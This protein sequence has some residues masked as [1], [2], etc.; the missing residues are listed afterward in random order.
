M[1]NDSL[2]NRFGL[3]DSSNAAVSKI[4]RYTLDAG[5]VTVDPTAGASRKY[6]R[7][8]PSWSISH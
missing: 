8:V 1:T 3:A 5:L 7:Y 2:R 6:A 4:I